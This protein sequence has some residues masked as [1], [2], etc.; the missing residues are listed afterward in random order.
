MIRFSVIWILGAGSL[1]AAEDVPPSVADAFWTTHVKS[2]VETNCVRCH[3]TVR[4]KAGVDLRSPAAARRGSKKTERAIVVPGKPEESSLYRVLLPGADPHMPPGKKQLD[5]E[6]IAAVKAWIE[7]LGEAKGPADKKA[8]EA[9]A[10]PETS[11]LPSGVSPRLVIDLLIEKG[12]RDRK[13]EP[14]RP[15][16]DREF[17]RRVYLDLAGRIPTPAELKSFEAETSFDKRELLVDRLLASDDYPRHMREVFDVVFLGRESGA[18]D[19]KT[20]RSYLERSFRENRP[21]N[22]IVDDLIVARPEAKEQRGAVEFIRARKE[23]KD[24]AALFAPSVLGLQLACAQCHDHPIAPEIEQRHYWGMVA[25][26][27]RSKAVSTPEGPAI[28]E[29]AVGGYDKFADLDGENHKVYPVFL[30]GSSLEEDWPADGKKKD[31]PDFY[32]KKDPKSK[33]PAIPKNSRREGLARFVQ[34]SPY[35]A[36]ALV[37]RLWALYFGRGIVHPVDKMDSAHPPSHPM[38]LDWLA[39]DVRTNGFDV[40]RLVKS[41]VLSRAYGLSSESDQRVI[42]DAF[43]VAPSKP[44]SAESYARS[45]WI[46]VNGSVPGARDLA[47]GQ[48]SAD[49]LRSAIVPVFPELFPEDPQTTLKQAL[50]L[51]N[52]PL[53]EKLLEPTPG[54]VIERALK[55]KDPKERVR[56]AVTHAFGRTPDAA[57]L[58]QASAFLSRA[59][60]KPDAAFRQLLWALITSAEFR[61]NH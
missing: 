48:V 53:V 29:S 47:E 22:E 5:P 54:T 31:S 33:A 3:G 37:N 8:V 24:V 2:V 15:A 32:L 10:A 25:F 60:A 50:F 51:T 34:Q 17:A 56:L 41:I 6:S 43:A 57:E 20:W 16:N 18:K 44:M 36:R 38:L 13:V 40:K 23:A 49:Q 14:A 46:A 1:M 4:R 35:L 61:L 9:K 28:A 52:H 42:A 55:L 39:Q 26:F 12:W 58:D 19:A 59:G 27:K 7:R 21:W 11:S 30:D 45:L